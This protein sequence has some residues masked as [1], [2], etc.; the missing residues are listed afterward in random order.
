MSVSPVT[1]KTSSTSPNFATSP[2]TTSASAVSTLRAMSAT[3]CSSPQTFVKALSTARLT[4]AF[5]A[6]GFSI[7]VPPT[8]Y[9][10]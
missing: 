6:E 4:G 7:M 5:A 9:P 8:R 2:A 1:R 3:T 10:Y